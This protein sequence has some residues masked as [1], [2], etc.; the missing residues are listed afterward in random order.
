MRAHQIYEWI[1]EF[2]WSVQII[3][4]H[5]GQFDNSYFDCS[6]YQITRADAL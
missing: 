3:F 5:G 2:L 4:L 1:C 6:R